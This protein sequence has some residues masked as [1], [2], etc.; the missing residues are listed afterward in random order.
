MKW[1]NYD[2]QLRKISSN[3]EINIYQQLIKSILRTNQNEE[4][5]NWSNPILDWIIDRS[6]IRKYWYLESYA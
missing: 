4:S 3:E 6:R 1:R 5:K 2:G